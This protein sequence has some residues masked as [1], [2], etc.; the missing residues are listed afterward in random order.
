MMSKKELQKWLE[1]SDRE[2]EESKERFE[3]A[4][5]DAIRAL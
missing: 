4:Y 1:E 3:K 5:Q 2:L